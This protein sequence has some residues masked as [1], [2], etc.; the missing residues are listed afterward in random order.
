MPG[1]T[2]LG[3][4]FSQ[5]GRSLSLTD[6]ISAEAFDSRHVYA[7]ISKRAVQCDLVNLRGIS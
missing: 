6:L 2:V 5:H 7:N 4:H 3:C 1:K